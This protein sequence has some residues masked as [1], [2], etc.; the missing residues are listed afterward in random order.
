MTSA[1]VQLPAHSWVD[2]PN[3]LFHPDRRSDRSPHPLRGLL[4]Y[5]PFGRSLLNAVLDPIRVAIVAPAG[6]LTL[7]DRLLRELD[8]THQPR[9]RK[10]YLPPYPGFQRVFGLRVVPAAS[11]ARIELP[12]T[13]DDELVAAPLPHIVLAERVAQVI[14]RLAALRHE[15]DVVCIYLPE[16]WQPAFYGPEGDDFDLHAFIKATAAPQQIATQLLREAKVLKYACRCSV[17]W[18]LAIALYTKA[19]GTPWRLADID[20]ETALIGIGYGLRQGGDQRFVTCASHVFD[21]SGS[22][23]EFLVYGTDDFNVVGDS[24]YL[25]RAD[26]HRVIARSM[27]VYQRRHGGRS[28]R[29]VVVHKTTEF[30]VDEVD[31]CFDA[32]HASDAVELIQIQQDSLWRGVQIEPPPGGRGR[33]NASPYPCLRGTYQPLGA[34]EVLLWTQGDVPA[35]VKKGQHYYKEGKGIPAPLLLRRFAGHGG[36]EETCRTILAFTKMNWNSDSLYDRAPVTIESAGVLADVVKRLP[37][38]APTPYQFRYFM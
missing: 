30:K 18:R 11:V 17:A 12:R 6:E 15:Y 25:T 14:G 5:G 23:F 13:L 34:T 38:F 7:V 28:P 36:W 16:R 31:G 22:G 1:L 35:V 21:A 8:Q 3:L 33:G 9:E 20:P 37:S 10:Q 2:E 19:G 4:E 29:R 24:P 27:D 32:L 26:M